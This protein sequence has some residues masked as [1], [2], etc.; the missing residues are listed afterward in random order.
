MNSLNILIT[1][2]NCWKWF[3]TLISGM[4][5]EEN[6]YTTIIENQYKQPT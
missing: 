3:E 6:T 1:L 2:L 5:K 4:P